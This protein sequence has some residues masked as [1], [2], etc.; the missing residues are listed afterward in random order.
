MAQYFNKFKGIKRQKSYSVTN[1][2]SLA[3]ACDLAYKNKKKV[4]DQA[5]KWGF[6]KVKFEEI[7]NGGDIDTQCYVMANDDDIVIAFRG[8]SSRE[9]W[10]TNIQALKDPGPFVGSEV[11]EGFQDAL[12]PA[13]IKVTSLVE[14]YRD[15]N[16]KIWVTGHSLGGALCSLYA[17]MLIENDFDVYGI[18]T[19]ASP[20]PGDDFFSKKLSAQVSGPHFRVVN[21]GDIVPH[22]PPEPFYSHA[23]KRVILTKSSRTSLKKSWFDERVEALKEF[24]N[25]TGDILEAADIHRLTADKNYSY[26]PRLI[27][28]YKK[29]HGAP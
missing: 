25:R 7:K 22:L 19:F 6:P 8:S 14:Q 12:Y 18:Y 28:E 20:R 29:A 26:I 13:V 2:L 10:V 3:I 24:V 17:A 21:T 16:Q 15:I 5:K 9:D 11:H 1:A 4:E 27:R 23:G